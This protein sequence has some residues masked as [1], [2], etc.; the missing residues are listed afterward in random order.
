M[1][2]LSI[3]LCIFD[4]AVTESQRHKDAVVKAIHL[5]LGPLSGVVKQA[6]ESAFTLACEGTSLGGSKLVI[7]ETRICVYCEVC[8]AECEVES[9]QM[10]R[11][12]QC[13]TPSSQIVRGREMDVIAL[14]L[15][16][17]ETIPEASP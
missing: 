13:G 2:E 8:Q 11:C 17:P 5:Q 7:E 14:E 3:A 6:L 10:L 15:E 16:L 12:S 9:I 1:H 4:I